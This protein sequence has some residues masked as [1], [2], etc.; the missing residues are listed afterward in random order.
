MARELSLVSSV[1]SASMMLLFHTFSKQLMLCNGLL[2][3]HRRVLDIK[4]TLDENLERSRR[5][6][7]AARRRARRRYVRL[8]ALALCTRL[9]HLH[10]L[11]R[12][13]WRRDRPHGEVFWSNVLA[14]FDDEQWVD[15]FR[16]SRS[17]FEFLLGLVETKLRRK[18]TRWRK[19]LEPRRRLAIVLWW[20]ATPSEYRTI[21]CLFGV[22]LSTVCTLVR[23]VTS[24]LNTVILKQFITLPE[25]EILQNT[26]R[27]FAGRGYPMCAGAINVTH[28][29][30][31][32]PRENPAAYFNNKKWHSIILQ[33]VVDHNMCFTDIYVGYPG[34]TSNARLLASSPLYK[35]AEEQDG[36]LFPREDALT[37]NGVE[38]PVHLIGSAAYPLKKW[39]MKGFTDE[40]SLTPEQ[41][42]FNS[43]LNSACTVAENAF[44]RL[45]GRWRCLLKRNDV[46]VAFMPDIVTACCILHNVCEMNKEDFL[47]E[48][49]ADAD[50]VLQQPDT[51][52]YR[53]TV[54]DG[55]RA[56]RDTMVTIV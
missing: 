7:E 18:S 15:H 29:P 32:S 51:D 2:S 25:G 55:T 8:R 1:D 54:M 4:R 48:W 19:A 12:R 43:Q 39:L 47:P 42:H 20:Y 44:G 16:M 31:S 9:L 45:K 53:D 27:G 36:Y 28:I 14:N 50:E 35:K 38:I 23:Q 5:E 26:L 56:I 41:R 17:T 6:Y 21:S 40:H 24:A 33:A 22:G 37:V 46:D 49:T 34:R 52:L 10:G 3:S 30:I 13:V 11:E